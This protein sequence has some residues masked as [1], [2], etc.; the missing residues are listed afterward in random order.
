MLVGEGW[1]GDWRDDLR[2]RR[3]QNWIWLREIE[4]IGGSNGKIGLRTVV[5]L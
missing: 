2:R 1:C 3:G 5:P 4:W